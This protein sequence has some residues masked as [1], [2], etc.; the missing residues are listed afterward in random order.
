MKG[1]FINI[2]FLLIG[3]G[4]SAQDPHFSQFFM[5]PH[6][7]NPANTGTGSGN[8]R[9]ISN[10][11]SQWNN[12]GTAFNTITLTG[13]NKFTGKEEGG[14]ILGAG[15][16]VMSDQSLYG[17][18]KS[19]YATGTLAYHVYLNETNRIGAGFSVTHGNRR[20]DYSQLTFGEQ[21]TSGGFDVSLPTGETALSTMKPFT[22]VGAGLLYSFASGNFNF[23]LG[24]AAYH[25]N[26]PKQTLLG[27]PEQIIPLRY[28]L[29][30]NLAYKPSD[31]LL[32]NMNSV[33]MRQASQNYVA[34]GGSA[35]LVVKDDYN[36]TI[37]FAGAWYR[38]GDAVY[39]YFALRFGGMQ[40]GISYDITSSG[41]NK[42]P[43][44]P[45]SFE[46]SLMFNQ[47]SQNPGII[48][49]PWR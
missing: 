12:A 49:C 10:F 14:N 1:L 27:D 47:T 4:L 21:F 7:V 28:V 22:S 45:R 19:T 40:V 38:Q 9:L 41:Q 43:A 35:G 17:A 34:A 23:E 18:F 30:M 11:R 3:S 42:G 2:I 5:A 26:K 13:E 15:F 25:L 33:Y 46:L 31:R 48:K 36:P 29:Q 37:I 16:T 20:L 8:W 44:N 24:T 39:P 6:L 32:L